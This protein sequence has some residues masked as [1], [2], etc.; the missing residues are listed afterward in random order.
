M[1][2][3]NV[4]FMSTIYTLH[5][6]VFALIYNHHSRPGILKK[7][8]LICHSCI[9]G[10]RFKAKTYVTFIKLISISNMHAQLLWWVIHS[11]WR[12]LIEKILRL[13]KNPSNT[14]INAVSNISIN[15]QGTTATIRSSLQRIQTHE[16]D[17][18]HAEAGKNTKVKHASITCYLD[19]YIIS[20]ITI[21]RSFVSTLKLKLNNNLIKII[22]I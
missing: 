3:V 22:I 12:N 7:N 20:V 6:F 15:Q 13:C 2:W 5:V 10:A 1:S 14:L 18:L 8:Q 11:R 4:I 19:F 9:S 16:S 17:S 21:H